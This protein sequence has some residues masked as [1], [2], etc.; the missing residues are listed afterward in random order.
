MDP[1]ERRRQRQPIHARDVWQSRGAREPRAYA[2]QVSQHQEDG[3]DR[4]HRRQP[5]RTETLD[6][7]A[8]RLSARRL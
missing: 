4:R 6:Q 3:D 5:A 8:V 7:A 2:T 1:P